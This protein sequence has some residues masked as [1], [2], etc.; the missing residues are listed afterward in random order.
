MTVPGADVLLEPDPQVEVQNLAAAL[1]K[2]L[3]LV[4]IHVTTEMNL[5]P[6]AKYD[7][8]HWKLNTFNTSVGSS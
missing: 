7:W 1:L 8:K 2:E 4:W 3:G 6:I 5:L